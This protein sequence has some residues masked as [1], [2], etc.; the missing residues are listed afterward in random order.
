MIH[1]LGF[2][3]SLYG[4]Y[5]DTNTGIILGEA[6]VVQTTNSYFNTIVYKNAYMIATTNVVNAAK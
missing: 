1:I 4:S 5:L 6:S 3:A 2:D